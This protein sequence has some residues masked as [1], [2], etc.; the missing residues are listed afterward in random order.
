MVPQFDFVKVN[1]FPNISAQWLLTWMIPLL[2]YSYLVNILNLN[3]E[4]T[5]SKGTSVMCLPR[6]NVITCTGHCPFLS[7]P[8]ISSPRTPFPG[9]VCRHSSP[10]PHT[11]SWLPHAYPPSVSLL[12]ISPLSGWVVRS[13]ALFISLVPSSSIPS[14][15]LCSLALEHSGALP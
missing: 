14:L 5:V 2:K 10:W 13:R 15:A 12:F 1:N 3:S 6:C 7:F 8:Y 4:W 9:H 11:D